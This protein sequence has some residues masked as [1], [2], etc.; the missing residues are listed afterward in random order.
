MQSCHIQWQVNFVGAFTFLLSFSNSFF[1]KSY[2]WPVNCVFSMWGKFQCIGYDNTA[3]VDFMDLAVCCP[4][5][6][7]KFN[8]SITHFVSWVTCI[9][10]V[11]F[12]MQ[13]HW[14]LKNSESWHLSAPD[15]LVNAK[16]RLK[17]NKRRY[18]NPC[19][20][21]L[22]INQCAMPY[23]SHCRDNYP[24]TL[25]CSQVSATHLKWLAWMIAYQWSISGNGQQGNTPCW[26][27]LNILILI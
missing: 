25:S 4:R 27:L 14:W 5:K 19:G 26:S 21:S 1:L 10:T 12:I 9:I 18:F 23:G 15:F 16:S 24:G 8:H 3:Y 20:N 11:L 22:I 13:C 17:N 6:A 2:L 7:V